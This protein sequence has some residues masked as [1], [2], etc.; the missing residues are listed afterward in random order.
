VNAVTGHGFTQKTIIFPQQGTLLISPLE[1]EYFL[2]GM[3]F[4]GFSLT[5]QSRQAHTPPVPFKW[6]KVEP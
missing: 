6:N 2:F 3:N 1:T 4:S 5:S